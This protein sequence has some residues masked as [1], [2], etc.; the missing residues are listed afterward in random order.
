M[1][2]AL[3]DVHIEEPLRSVLLGF[4]ERSS[5]YVVNH[6]EAPDFEE[7]PFNPASRDMR[8]EISRRWDAQVGLDDDGAG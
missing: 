5:A 6:G 4:F 1:A 7:V 2:S 8:E 3:N